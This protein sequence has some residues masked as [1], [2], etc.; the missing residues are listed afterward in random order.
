M[1]DYFV[2]FNGHLVESTRPD[3]WPKVVSDKVVVR[4]QSLDTLVNAVN[5]KA[6]Q[7]KHDGGLTV[8]M[9]DI[10]LGDD[11]KSDK[12]FGKGIYVPM[13]MIA[14]ISYTVRTLVTVVPDLTGEEKVSLQ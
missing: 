1:T 8:T 13:H 14:Y 12:G 2:S 3:G 6:E 5:Q 9:D 4:S 7:I 11:L 10:D